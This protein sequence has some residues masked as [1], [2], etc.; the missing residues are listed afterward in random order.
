MGGDGGIHIAVPAAMAFADRADLLLVGDAQQIR[1]NFPNADQRCEVIDA[2]EVVLPNDSLSVV[3]RRKPGSSMRAAL[4][5]QATDRADA[6]VSGGDTAALMALSRH[7][8][9]MVPGVQRPAIARELLGKH[10]SFWLADL[11]ANVGASA[12]QI[13]Q[14]ALMGATAAKHVSNIP[15]PRIALMNIGTEHSKGPKV[16]GEADALLRARASVTDGTTDR[17][18]GFVEGTALFDNTADV[19]ACDGF[20]GNIALK[21]IEGAA[22]MAK[23]LLIEQ[24][25]AIR[26]WRRWILG[27]VQT[28]A[29]DLA[30]AFGT[31]QY[32]G[33]SFLG[34]SGSVIKSHG[35]ASQ[36]GFE[37]AINR[38]LV[39]ASQEL[40]GMIAADIRG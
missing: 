27:L 28:S 33:A 16:L 25:S 15:T 6:T 40:P 23:H 8:L 17:Y 22:G 30:G 29:S 34:L 38:A 26:G 4:L 18:I 37:S 1:Q 39:E 3:L 20:A 7:I 9:R 36:T 5:M 10:G 32:N 11:G 14:F 21:A 12:E 35:G 19:I 2:P 31:E 24:L 13:V